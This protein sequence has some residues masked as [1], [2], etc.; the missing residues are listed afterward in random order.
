MGF[1]S[2]TVRLVLLAL[3]L[4]PSLRAATADRV[5]LKDGTH[6]DGQIL[7]S[8]EKPGVLVVNVAPVRGVVDRREVPK[9]SVAS[10]VYADGADDPAFLVVLPTNSPPEEWYAER[11]RKDLD[12]WLAQYPKSPRLAEMQARRDAFEAERKRVAAGDIRRGD[13]WLSPAEAVD[14]APELAAEALLPPLGEVARQ[15]DAVRLQALLPQIDKVASAPSYPALVRAALPALQ[16]CSAVLQ[17]GS[18]ADALRKKLSFYQSEQDRCASEIRSVVNQKVE[19]YSLRPGNSDDY[20]QVGDLWYRKGSYVSPYGEFSSYYDSSVVGGGIAVAL[21]DDTLAT[22]R[23]WLRQIDDAKAQVAQVQAAL[24]DSDAALKRLADALRQWQTRFAAEPVAQK[25]ATVAA[26][27]GAG[28]RIEAGDWAGAEPI[29]A[30]ANK[31]W[32]NNLVVPLTVTDKAPLF[33]AR[34]D[35]AVKAGK[36]AE[37]EAIQEQ[38]ARLVPYLLPNSVRTRALQQSLKDGPDRIAQSLVDHL[39]D[40][41]LHRSFAEFMQERAALLQTVQRLKQAKAEQMAQAIEQKIQALEKD[42]GVQDAL[43]AQTACDARDFSAVIAAEGKLDGGGMPDGVRAWYR[44]L[45]AKAQARM[46]ESDAE[47]ARVNGLLMHANL[48]GANAAL[49]HAGEIWPGNPSIE[50]KKSVLESVGGVAGGI[51]VCIL[52]VALLMG[53]NALSTV[54][55]AFRYKVTKKKYARQGRK[56]PKGAKGP[57]A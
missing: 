39:R 27:R 1:S 54:L 2:G 31:D 57:P 43:S 42:G 33:L 20:T 21:S 55:E 16:A 14:W 12:P 53:W 10:I 4:A 48:L 29:L 11:L 7:F 49:R 35:T 28:D 17:P 9:E 8:E 51:A 23:G 18:Y 45:R 25:E 40:T 36:L 6:L 30:Q 34:M 5:E 13:R 46:D 22:A 24:A 26:V 56:G 47:L 32:P 52:I 44:D 15:S 3:F 38:A 50:E 19:G 41:L 37:A